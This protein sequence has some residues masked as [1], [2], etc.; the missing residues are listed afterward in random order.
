MTA[1]NTQW[2]RCKIDRKLLKSLSERSDTIPLIWFGAYL[3]LV[4]GLGA[5]VV[6][7]WGQP[8]CIAFIVL[9]GLAWGAA[10]SA[11]HETCHG[12]PFKTRWLNEAALWIFGWMVQMEPIAVRYGHAGHHSYT[13][14][15]EGDTELSEP[16]PVT[17]RNF[18]NVGLGLWG[19]LFYWRALI[20]QAVGHIPADLKAIIPAKELPLA[21]LN[22][23]AM[24]ALYAGFIVWA[25]AIGSWMPVVL[26]FL[27]R[28]VGGPV[29]GFLHLTQHTCLQMNILDHR[30]ST[31]SFTV[32]PVTRFFYFNMN[33]H[34]EHH[35][36]PMVP[37]YNLPKLRA[38][39]RD[40]LPEPCKGLWGVYA[41]IL[42]AIVRQHREPG[43]HIPRTVP[44]AA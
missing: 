42:P 12:T 11:V 27:P 40:Q 1:L 10:A 6:L 24:V 5:G 13:H 30:Y 36:F 25:V 19:A 4:A 39:I 9:Q 41:E 18:F 22:A 34:I 3:V 17:W 20:A 35:M 29:T 31:R 21:Y 16:N 38:A 28:I 43:Y 26:A 15:E 7:T 23:R 2:F 33:H 14:F 8:Q 37:F 44:G 32:G